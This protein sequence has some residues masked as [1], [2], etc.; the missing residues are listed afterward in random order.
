MRFVLRVWP[1]NDTVCGDFV[2][3]DAIRQRGLSIAQQNHVHAATLARAQ[4][5]VQA[6]RRLFAETRWEIGTNQESIRLC[7]FARSIVVRIDV[8]EFVAQVLLNHRFH[9]L[10]EINQSLLDRARI[11][12]NALANEQLKLIAEMHKRRET[13]AESNRINKGESRLGRRNRNEDSREE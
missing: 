6:R 2:D 3:R 1:N 11:R 8:F 13:L 7:D 12:P 9:V 10:G 5:R 4:N